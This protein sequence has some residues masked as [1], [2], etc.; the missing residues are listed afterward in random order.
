MT[1]AVIGT[2]VFADTSAACGPFRTIRAAQAAQ[3][4]MDG[5]GWNTELV[6]ML[7]PDEL[8]PVTND[9]GAQL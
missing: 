5:L 4:E 6:Q 2:N 3:E 9:E 8:E 1:Y 7:R